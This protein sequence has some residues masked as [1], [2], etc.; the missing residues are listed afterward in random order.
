[1]ITIFIGQFVNTAI[2]IVLSNASFA[3]HDGGSGPLSLIFTVGS[4]TDFSVNWY[5]GVGTAI[6][7]NMTSQALWPLIEFA[8]FWSLMTFTRCLDNGCSRDKYKTKAPS[9]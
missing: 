3:D 8:I 7:T 9:V 4:E 5:K 6:M 1:M 2:L